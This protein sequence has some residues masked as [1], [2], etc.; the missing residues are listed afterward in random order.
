MLGENCNVVQGGFPEDIVNDSVK[1]IQKNWK[2]FEDMT[3][4][5]ALQLASIMNKFPNDWEVLVES[6]MLIKD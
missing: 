3:P 1:Y 5:N 4:R 2:K 6:Q